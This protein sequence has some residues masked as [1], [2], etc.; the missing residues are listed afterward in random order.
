[1]ANIKSVLKTTKSLT[2]KGKIKGRNKKETRVLRAGCTHHRYNRSGSKIKATV[3]VAA[4]GTIF[5]PMCKAEFSE[6]II[7]HN[8][9]REI[10]AK[11]KEVLDQKTFMAVEANAGNEAIDYLVNFKSFF[12]KNTYKMLDKIDK[13]TV[14]K[15]GIQ[16][17][18]K[19]YKNYGAQSF[20]GWGTR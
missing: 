3:R 10:M 19:N 11:A 13:V 12:N 7:G 1:M 17:K 9:A 8:E 6:S 14:K 18:K 15:T 20:G 2:K 16:K 4:D 5:C